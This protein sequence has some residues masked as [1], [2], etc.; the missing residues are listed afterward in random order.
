MENRMRRHN[1]SYH[2]PQ[3]DVLEDRALPS[4]LGG[5]DF[6]PAPHRPGPGAAPLTYH[7]V[8]A[9]HVPR[10][11]TMHH[12]RH[13]DKADGT[14]GD[15]GNPGVLPPNSH[16]HGKSY[17]EWEAAFWQWALSMPADHNPLTDTAPPSSGQTD[18][19][20]FLGGTF[21]PT[22]GPGG[23]F[24]GR[25][26][27]DITVPAGTMLFFPVV[28]AEC[29]TAE[30]NGN[31]E[32]DLRSCAKS[33]ADFIDPASLFVTLDGL[34]FQNLAAY[35]AQSP[36]YTYGPLPA[37][38]LLGVPGGTVSPS[39]SDGYHIMLAPLAV[40]EHTLHFGGNLVA[41]PLNLT[42]IEDITYHITVA[43]R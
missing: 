23:E 38:N 41:A 29:S 27:R 32:A 18:H 4:S 30:G 43:P 3:F 21:A 36:V 2:H 42:F 14:T 37:N 17:G 24:I 10:H 25:V 8:P 13:A 7:L 26:A 16:P 6:A 34:S 20:W 28:N 19:V 35:R 40:G 5:L 11:V 12:G 15:L 22:V 39:V 9:A 33:L 1:G 31:T